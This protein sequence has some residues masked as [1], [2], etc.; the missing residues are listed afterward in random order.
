MKKLKIYLRIN[1]LF[2]LLSGILMA[3]FSDKLL[4]L[5]NIQTESNRYLF[6]FIG[7]NLIIFALFVWYVSVKHL[8]SPLLVRIISFLDFLWVLG[9]IIIVAFQ[10]FNLSISGYITIGVVA[11]W[12]G[13][14]A[15]NQ[16][17]NINTQIH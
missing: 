11:I 4:H 15:H 6:D 12:I 17:K 5:F 8:Q 9:S 3:E 14:L 16:L 13:F 2:S 7:L 1:S 10:L